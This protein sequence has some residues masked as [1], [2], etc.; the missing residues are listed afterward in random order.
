MWV[1]LKYACIATL[2]TAAVCVCG[3]F[4]CQMVIENVI[5][6]TMR[7]SSVKARK[8][9]VHTKTKSKRLA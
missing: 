9:K 2:K 7:Q 3:C 6:S 8:A 4:P 1:A 5:N